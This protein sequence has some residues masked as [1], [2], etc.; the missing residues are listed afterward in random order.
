MKTWICTFPATLFSPLCGAARLYANVKKNGF[1]VSFIDMNQKAFFSLLSPESLEQVFERITHYIFSAH[2]SSSFRRN[3]GSILLNSSNNVIRQPLILDLLNKTPLK[4][5]IKRSN[6]LEKYLCKIAGIKVT[7]DNIYYLL[8]AGKD[9]IV[10]DIEVSRQ[11]LLESFLILSEDDFIAN[12]RMLLCGKALIDTVY[13]PA[14]LDFGFGFH[15]SAYKMRAGDIIHAASDEKH[16]CMIPYFN[17]EIMPL[18]EAEQPEFVGLSITHAAD[19]VPTFTL[20]KMIRERNPATHICLGGATLTELAYR[21]NKN[22]LLWNYFDSLVLGPGENSF[23]ELIIS[24]ENKKTLSQVPNLVYKEKDTIKKSNI[25]YELN[26][27]ETCTPEFTYML[28]GSVLPLETAYGCYWS[29]CIFCYYPKIGLSDINAKVEKNKKVRNI[30]LVLEDIDQL[31]K[32][33]KPSFIGLIDSAVHPARLMKIAEHNLNSGLKFSFSAFFRFEREFLSAS[34]CR[35]LSQ[36]RF[37]GGQA[38]LESGSQKINNLINKGVDLEDIKKILK[39]FYKN[40]ISTHLYAVIGIPGEKKSDGEQTFRF[41]RKM[42]KYATLFWQ[43]YP[44]GVLEN[45]PLAGRAEELGLTIKPLPD[46]SL[47]QI[48]IHEVKEGLSQIESA[49]LSIQYSEKL[50]PY[51]HSYIDFIDIESLKLLLCVFKAKNSKVLRWQ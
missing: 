48:T 10:A 24:I 44:M 15:G 12:Y 38:G 6:V 26:I 9:Q 7:T 21:I 23:E 4:T 14:Q 22:P 28:P 37:L 29:K 49:A 42:R 32:K 36:G 11:R 39:N 19:F 18:F 33:Y 51:L 35:K 25:K 30:E 46:D 41:I 43:I 1:D 17:R 16:N 5:Y 13:F 34:F 47:T 27:N 45:G 3:I 20:A 50:K 2:M 31:Q 40:N 8:L